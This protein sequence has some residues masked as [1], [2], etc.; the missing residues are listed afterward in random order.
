MRRRS[1]AGGKSPNAQAPKAAARKSRIAG[2]AVHPCGSSAAREETEVARLTRERDE[3]LEQQA[4][5]SDILRGISNSP[6]DVQ[7]VLDS[8]AQ[9]A[10]RICEAQIVDISI[11]DNQVFRTAAT[12]GELGRQNAPR[13]A[14]PP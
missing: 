11:V 7:P 3:A 6:G 12:F 5:I 13:R 4:A 2:K 10:A 8:V 1:S 14:G 9:H